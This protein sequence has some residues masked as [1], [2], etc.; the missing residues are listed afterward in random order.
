MNRITCAALSGVAA[1]LLAFSAGVSAQQ[2]PAS[3]LLPGCKQEPAKRQLKT[4]SQKFIKQVTDVDN[5]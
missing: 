3:K 5:L 4:V 1:V 2:T